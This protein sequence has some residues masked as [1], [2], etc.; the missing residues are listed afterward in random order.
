MQRKIED[1]KRIIDLYN[2]GLS[3]RAI[4]QQ[5]RVRDETIR[6]GLLRRGITMRPNT[7]H[8]SAFHANQQRLARLGMKL[9][10]AG[11]N[12]R[13]MLRAM[14]R[15]YFTVLPDATP[16]EVRK[17]FNASDDTI[18]RAK[19]EAEIPIKKGRPGKVVKPQ[20]GSPNK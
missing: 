3:T 11:R 2:G 10:D 9:Q 7:A 5:F 17:V 12:P 14:L 19:H 8:L 18:A 6:R 4:G 1:W 16:D 15:L 20:L 13:K